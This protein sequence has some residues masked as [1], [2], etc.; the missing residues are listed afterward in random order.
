[1][2]LLPLRMSDSSFVVPVPRPALSL[3]APAPDPLLPVF[4]PLTATELLAAWFLAAFIPGAP[5]AALVPLGVLVA[6][7]AGIL[8]G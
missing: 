8:D 5:A 1:M 2:A 7:T 6:A 4:A 3:A